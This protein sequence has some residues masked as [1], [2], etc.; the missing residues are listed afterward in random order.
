[1][2]HP[3]RTK[4]TAH[5]LR[6]LLHWLLAGGALGSVP[7]ALAQ[8]QG[9]PVL[10][11]Q[12]GPQTAAPALQE[13]T[14]SASGLGLSADEM[15]TPVT[16]LAGEALVQR[17]SATLGDTLDGEAGIHATHFGQGASRPIIRGME[18]P[19]VQI[20]SDG[21]E[22]H[23]ASTI[24]P[25]HNVAAEPLLATQIEVLRGPG[26]LIYG[27]GSAMGGAINILDDK[28]P[29]AIP[30]KGIEGS[31]QVRANSAAEEKA[32]A[33]AI[34]G[35]SGQWALHA[36][37]V[38]REA[39][40]YRVGG[41]WY[42]DDGDRLRRVPGSQNKT[43]TGSIGAS[44]ID[45]EGRGHLGLAYTRQSGDYGIPGHDHQDCHTHG[46]SLHCGADDDD[47][48][49]HTHDHDH[50]G[51]V[52]VLDMVS[53]RWDVRGEW[54]NPGSGIAALR[55]RAG[56]VDYRH[57]ELEGGAIETTFLNKAHDIRLEMEHT[58][59]W[60]G[61]RGV[62]GVQT[63]QRKFSAEGEEAYVEPTRTR[64][65]SLYLME[66]YVRDNWR[67]QAAL[68]HER[69]TLLARSTQ[70]KR[71]HN[72]TSASFGAVWNFTP[73][74]Q[75]TTSLTRGQRLPTA[76]EL[77]ANGLHLGTSSFERGNAGLRRETSQA[78]DMGVRKTAG[79]T[80]F[81]ANLFHNRMKGYI[82]GATLDMD[83]GVQ[84]LQYTQA[85][86]TFTGLEWQ[87]H[88]KLTRNIGI[89]VFG[90]TV[91]AKRKSGGYLPRIPAARAG[92]RL[93]TRWPDGWSGQVEWLHVMKQDRLARFES[94]TRG[95]NLLN[96]AASYTLRTAGGTP[97]QVFIQGRNLTDK[98]AWAHTSF[99]KNAA[100]LAGRNISVGVK[101][102]F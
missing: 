31:A 50:A 4:K 102:D 29:A 89:G 47:D 36:E 87:A 67:W 72:G 53:D 56:W 26:A 7:A 91:R 55:L 62:L 82:Y 100:P 6:P 98:L 44:W 60:G 33:F 3:S 93:D 39:G 18:G 78:I 9:A 38:V 20:L 2:T 14:V 43:H 86:A 22:V 8:Q 48:H 52:P 21:I 57:D 23:D 32:G 24:S 19:R 66:E 28:I 84:L 83:Q 59:L 25:D 80:T 34:T 97:W 30:D 96:L 64:R 101:V 79:D 92:L 74:Y 42:D 35:G 94:E 70:R 58:P 65:H 51:G 90:D 71:E 95:Y 13:I 88:H 16:V 41:T 99:I 69:Q 54:R 73:G 75:L 15:S 45:D 11:A 81:G 17:Q 10:L 77:Y 5:R 1:M 12:A 46:S 63:M 61:W 76:E 49:G 85:D 27:G 68:R 37:G 40:E